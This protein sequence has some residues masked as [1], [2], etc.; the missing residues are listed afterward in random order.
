M[1]VNVILCSMATDS[2]GNLIRRKK[3]IKNT[4]ATGKPLGTLSKLH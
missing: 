1:S 4:T 3:F 2:M